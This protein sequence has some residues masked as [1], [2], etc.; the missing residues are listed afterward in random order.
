[1]VAALPSESFCSVKE[2]VVIAHSD[3]RGA[4]EKKD[5]LHDER[6]LGE[7]GNHSYFR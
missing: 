1:V 3:G 6:G 5:D 2:L 4:C 7:G